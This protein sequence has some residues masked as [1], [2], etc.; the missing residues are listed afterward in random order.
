MCAVAA[1]AAVATLEGAQVKVEEM[2]HV[3][4]VV[5]PDAGE[6]VPER[7]DDVVGHYG[8]CSLLFYVE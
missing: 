4:D 6:E 7:L 1:A 8:C 3:D 2:P 5:V